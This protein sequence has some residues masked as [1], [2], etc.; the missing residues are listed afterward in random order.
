MR[1]AFFGTP[2]FALPTLQALFD[3]G[4]EV[5]A[6]VAQPDRPVGRGQSLASP[7]TVML[8]RERDVPVYQPTKLKSGDF[9]MQ[10][11][12]LGVEVAVVVAYGRILP[13]AILAAPA[14]GCINVH[15]SLLPRWRGAAPIQ[16][17]VLAGDEQAGITTM[18][19]AEGLDTGDMLLHAST[20]IGSE[21]TSGELQLRLAPMGAA[22]LIETLRRL[23]E[24]RPT[25]Q[26]E[27]LATHAP[28]L[29][30]AMSPIDWTHSAVAIHRQ[31]RGL[32]PWPGT[33]ANVRGETVKI[34]RVALAEGGGPAGTLLA[35]ACVACGEGAVRLVEVQA[36]GKKPVRGTDFVNGARLAM[37]SRL[38][39]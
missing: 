1:V 15:G 26:D 32:S 8:A 22:L 36:P 16:W 24:L 30:R 6:V 37:G 4:H 11:S 10:F 27:S 14:K 21:E 7:P 20:P 25:P 28:M 23:P 39:N 2:A 12:E 29:D 33:T 31:V 17:S 5:A 3:A 35:E 9:P 13:P 34:L 19:M 38:G 18:Q